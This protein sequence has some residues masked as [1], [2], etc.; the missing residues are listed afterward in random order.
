MESK[1][2]NFKKVTW[3]L[4]QLIMFIIFLVVFIGDKDSALRGAII[5][6]FLYILWVSLVFVVITIT[7]FINSEKNDERHLRRIAIFCA[8]ISVVIV[9]FFYIYYANVK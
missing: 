1:K 9:T 5:D 4:A 3:F 6:V 2:L 8:I 7:S